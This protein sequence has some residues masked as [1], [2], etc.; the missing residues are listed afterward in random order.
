MIIKLIFVLIVTCFNNLLSIELT[1]KLSPEVNCFNK[2]WEFISDQVM[3]GLS[4]GTLEIITEDDNF[5]Y[6]LNGKV[7]LE[8]NGGFIQ[9]RSII[10]LKKSDYEGIEITVR[11]NG[12]NYYTHL[13]T[14]YT[15]LPWQYYNHEIITTDS[16]T[17]L[18]IFFQNF[19]KSHFYQPQSFSSDDIKTIGFV[20]IGRNFDAQLDIKNI[21]FF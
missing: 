20:A 6:R 19:K 8:N 17:T 14:K 18:K 9:F 21:E 3:G 10:N 1:N 12:E 7:T 4:T 5:F 13:T 11:G 16:W 2:K 15:F